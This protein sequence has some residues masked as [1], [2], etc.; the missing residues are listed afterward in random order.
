[1]IGHVTQASA[2]TNGQEQA[3]LAIQFDKAVLKDK[4]EMPLNL[5]IQ[6]IAAPQTTGA[7]VCVRWF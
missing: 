1:L 3:V 2:R 7:F 4:Q 6:A 5:T